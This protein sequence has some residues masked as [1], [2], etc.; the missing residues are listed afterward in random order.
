M[1]KFVDEELAPYAHEI[2]ANNGFSRMKEFWKK[3]GNMGLLGI[4]ASPEYGGTGGT[5]LHHCI[6]LEE[7]SRGSGAIALSY[8]AHSNLCVNQI[9][10]NASEEQKQKYLTKVL[11]LF[12]R[13]SELLIYRSV[14]FFLEG[15]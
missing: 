13:K 8:G 3:L 11:K 7:I 14:I 4:T 10:R 9:V 12:L 2:D 6:A 1:R 15:Q 5:Y